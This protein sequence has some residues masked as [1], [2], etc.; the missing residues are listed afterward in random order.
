MVRNPIYTFELEELVR[1]YL[2]EGQKPGSKI[3]YEDLNLHI[4]AS[5]Y[6]NGLGKGQFNYL[7][8]RF[9][10]GELGIGNPNHRAAAIAAGLL[11]PSTAQQAGYAAPNIPKSDPPGPKTPISLGATPVKPANIP[12]R[13]VKPTPQRPVPEPHPYPKSLQVFPDLGLPPIGS[14]RKTD[15]AFLNS[16][17]PR[18]HEHPGITHFGD[19]SS[20]GSPSPVPTALDLSK[21]YSTASTSALLPPKPPTDTLPQPQ[22]ERVVPLDPMLSQAPIIGKIDGLA[23]TSS[24]PFAQAGIDAQMNETF[25]TKTG[26]SILQADIMQSFGPGIRLSASAREKLMGILEPVK[27]FEHPAP[28]R[29]SSSTFLNAPGN[30]YQQLQST[31]ATS[32]PMEQSTSHSSQSP[33]R[34]PSGSGQEPPRPPNLPQTSKPTSAPGSTT[35]K[36]NVLPPGGLTHPLPAKPVID[37]SQPKRVKPSNRHEPSSLS[38]STSGIAEASTASVQEANM[39]MSQ[40]GSFPSSPIVS[41]ARYPAIGSKVATSNHANAGQAGGS[42]P[43]ILGPNSGVPNMGGL[44]MH[45]K[46]SGA[47]G[48]IGSKRRFSQMESGGNAHGGSNELHMVP[49]V[50]Q[51]AG[52]VTRPGLSQFGS[53]PPLDMYS[54]GITAPS[55]NAQNLNQ[56][57]NNGQAPAACSGRIESRSFMLG[58]GKDGVKK[59][60]VK[61]EGSK[62]PMKLPVLPPRM[63]NDGKRVVTGQPNAIA[64]GD[65]QPN[66]NFTA[67]NTQ[68]DTVMMDDGLAGLSK[69]T[70][71]ELSAAAMMGNDINI[72][73]DNNTVATGGGFS[74]PPPAS[75]MDCSSPSDTVTQNG[76]PLDAEPAP[77]YYAA[78]TDPAP[79]DVY[80]CGPGTEPCPISSAVVHFHCR[81]NG[82][83][84]FGGMGDF[85]A[86]AIMYQRSE[87]YQ[88]RAGPGVLNANET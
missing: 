33:A 31:K 88:S 67:E 24:A 83:V 62:S 14:H 43:D 82:T 74:H 40:A 79:V 63:E 78:P 27:S 18:N 58:A 7:K 60:P 28:R 51:Q 71:E 15:L 46:P 1:R 21:A 12:A 48:Q 45:G 37:A 11:D 69:Y 17:R 36:S 86:A 68:A 52:G 9:R 30:Q 59:E 73:P 22:A 56:H 81:R 76:P 13:P 80:L 66:S 53:Y 2:E 39:R 44:I 6:G 29:Q 70:N 26:D 77:T 42:R 84:I 35:I 25:N 47:G 8:T 10:N 85:Q 41:H 49:G 4:K 64:S 19:T 38:M 54:S 75:Q 23:S 3:G 87:Q 72:A 65:G 61:P 34:Q 50:H 5:G 32:G 57:D 16:K 55:G 20:S